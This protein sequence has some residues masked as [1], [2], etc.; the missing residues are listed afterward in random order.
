[1]RYVIA[2]TLLLAVGSAQAAECDPA[3]SKGPYLL[4]VG[5]HKDV[6]LW[7]SMHWN[8]KPPSPQAVDMSCFPNGRGPR[9]Q[10]LQR[11]R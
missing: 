8:T 2:A 3:R 6:P 7:F 1:M 9:V 4:R 11:R 5:E 10:R